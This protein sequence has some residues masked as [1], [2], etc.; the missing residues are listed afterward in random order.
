MKQVPAHQAVEE[1]GKAADRDRDRGYSLMH[2][3]SSV[4][5]VILDENMGGTMKL[6]KHLSDEAEIWKCW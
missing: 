4:L 2:D 1:R 6:M 5:I 3:G